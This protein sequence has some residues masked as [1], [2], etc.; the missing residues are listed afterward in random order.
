MKR[1]RVGG[2][3]TMKIGMQF[4]VVFVLLALTFVMSGCSSDT[5]TKTGSS[6]HGTYIKAS[7]N[8][9]I[10]GG[11]YLLSFDETDQSYFYRNLNGSIDGITYT[12]GN[13]NVREEE[14]YV[15]LISGDLATGVVILGEDHIDLVYKNT[16]IRLS[17]YDDKATEFEEEKTE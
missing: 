4:K 2:L 14:Y 12:A 6:L 9:A 15:D 13:Y 10:P 5:S 11:E 16:M 1:L 17:K 7:E 8:P 3:K